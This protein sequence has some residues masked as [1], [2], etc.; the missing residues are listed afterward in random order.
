MCKSG[1]TCLLDEDVPPDHYALERVG[2]VMQGAA[3]LS[4][5]QQQGITSSVYMPFF[6][7]MAQCCLVEVD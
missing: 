4:G 1:Y 2:Y 3:D 5:T 6:W 7:N